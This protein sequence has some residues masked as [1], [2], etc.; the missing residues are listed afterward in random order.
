[1]CQ[2]NILIELDELYGNLDNALNYLLAVPPH[3]L[4]LHLEDRASPNHFGSLYIL[5]SN[6]TTRDTTCTDSCTVTRI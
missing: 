3:C 4:T 2:F 1:M 5:K 6:I